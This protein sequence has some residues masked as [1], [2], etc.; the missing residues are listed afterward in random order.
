M[1]GIHQIVDGRHAFFFRDIGDMG[2][3]CC[4]VRVGVTENGLDV[5][6]AQALF[7]QVG[8]KAVTE[9]MDG[10]FFLMPHSSTTTRIAF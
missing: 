1:N 9:G 7:K 3:S 8:G 5:A 6:E 2:V 10:D 4:R